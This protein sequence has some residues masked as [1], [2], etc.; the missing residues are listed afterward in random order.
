MQVALVSPE[1]ILWEGEATMVLAR[2]AGGDIAF[3]NNHAP[4]VGVLGAGRVLIRPAAGGAD[5]E[6]IVD[7][8]FVEV[9]DN[10]V[11]ILSDAAE[12]AA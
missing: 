8:G 1:R 9:K 3:L 7:G 12:L 4:F 10:R 11:T 6:A 2:S 5:V